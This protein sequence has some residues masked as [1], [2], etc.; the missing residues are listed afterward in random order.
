MSSPGQLT[1]KQKLARGQTTLGMWV[2]LESPTI[3]EIAV[4]LGFDWIVVDAEH[5]H[6][7]FKEILEHVRVTRNTATTP[8]VRIQEIEQG[9]I[10]RVL[11]IGARG[12][13]VPQVTRAAEVAQ[14]VRF[15]KYPPWGV[16]GVGGERATGWGMQLRSATQ[17]ANEETLVIPLM[18]TVAAG[19]AI[20]AILDVPGVDA[21]Y[22]G[23]ADYSASAGH[24][25]EWEGPGVA[26]RLLQIKDRIRARGFACGVMSTS[27]D[28][29]LLRRQQGFQMIGI[30]SDTGLLIRSSAQALKALVDPA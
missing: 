3:S 6:L 2:T 12:I 13:I 23:P 9:L 26:E 18:E 15:A 4:V 24:L 25:G 29:A 28:N 22:F 11:D 14:A 8:L 19:E 5:G 27:V 10:K 16:R 20:D 30:G 1:L 21:I 17:A 7:D